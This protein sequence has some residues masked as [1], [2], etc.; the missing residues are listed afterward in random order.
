MRIVVQT[1]VMLCMIHACQTET[2]D[3]SATEIS[4]RWHLESVDLQ[5]YQSS[6]TLTIANQSS[7][8]LRSDWTLYYN[9]FASLNA[10]RSD[11][12]LEVEHITGDYHR[13]APSASFAPLPPGAGRAFRL[14]YNGIMRR[15]SDA[16]HGMYLVDADGDVQQVALATSGVDASTL[17]ALNPPTPAT[18]FS[19][20]AMVDPDAWDAGI[21]IIPRPAAYAVGP[22][23]LRLGGTIRISFDPYP[24]F[25]PEARKLQ[26]ALKRY[27]AGTAEVILD[28]TGGEIHLARSRMAGQYAVEVNTDG[29][30][31]AGDA[32]ADV[33]YGIQSLLGLIPLRH[34]TSPSASLTLPHCNITDAPRFAYRGLHVDIARNFHSLDRLKRIVDQMAYFKLNRLHLTLTNDEGWRLEIPGLPELTEVGAYRG[35]TLDETTH[36]YPAYGSGPDPFAPDNNGSGFYSREEYIDLIRYAAERWVQIIP[37]IDVP[38]HARAAIKAMQAREQ[39]LMQ[40]G[41]PEE[42]LRYRLH[43]P[44]D[45][46]V[47]R[48]AQNYSDNV[49]CVCQE[50][51]YAFIEHVVNEVVKMHDEAGL[52]LLA[53]H[54]G[55]DEVPVGVWQGSPV[56][57]AWISNKRLA[58]PNA[59]GAYF[60]QRFIE[61]LQQHGLTAA[62][63]E[64][65]VLAMDNKG[66]NTTEINDRFI[67]QP[68]LPYVWNAVWG[69][70]REDMAY[71]LANAGYEI[72][73]CNSAA[74]YFDLAYDRDPLERGLS[75]SGYVDTRTVF[76]FLPLDMFAVATVDM[77]DNPLDPDHIAGMERITPEG[78]GRVQGIQGQLWG[79]TIVDSEL[80]DYYLFPKMLALAERAWAAAPDWRSLPTR[81]ERLAALE[82]DWAQFAQIAGRQVLPRLDVLFGGVAYRIP[83]PGAIVRN[84]TLHANVRFPGLQIRYTSDGARP[85]EEW[86]IYAEPVAIGT[87]SLVLRAFNTTGRA[88]RPVIVRH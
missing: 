67:G 57:A 61:I 49:I 9:Q 25:E 37:E 60:Q 79:E 78:A 8:T 38:G 74:L 14:R 80:L 18:R 45:T 31:I 63:W 30:R 39:R 32:P 81:E 43:D 48:S 73:I 4:I 46:S 76:D 62:G 24:G 40:E 26:Q 70:G 15:I 54:S 51:T 21:G 12:T 71:R 16:P 1:A 55:G 3:T 33:F 28:N 27:Y 86:S 75:W 42:A 65:I 36:L 22:D 77:Y 50:S 34:L 7:D 11:S 58:G 66:H 88:S 87:D 85:F 84:D 23:T 6:A 69:W 52:P 5:A 41:K 10:A 83:L 2:P 13:I 59:L 35:H 47:Y 56:C 19:E 72:V 53:I 64:E 17:A 82:R 20:N 44:Q 29:V 68:V